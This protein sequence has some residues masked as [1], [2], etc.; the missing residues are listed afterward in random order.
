MKNTL[1]LLLLISFL[2][3]C[4]QDSVEV[5]QNKEY[6]SVPNIE[7]KPKSDKTRIKNVILMIG[8]GM[9]LTQVYAGM[10]TNKGSLY[11]ENCKHIG[12]SKTYSSV[13]ELFILLL[14]SSIVS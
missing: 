11:L 14:D 4:G 6:Y 1:T 10:T 7:F 9:G 5:Y 3:A 2:S 12:L 8:D 13:Q